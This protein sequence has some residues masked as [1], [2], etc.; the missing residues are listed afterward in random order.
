[1]ISYVIDQIIQLR[2][3]V[4]NKE[5]NTKLATTA[6]INNGIIKLSDHELSK[7]TQ[8]LIQNEEQEGDD[9]E[10]DSSTNTRLDSV[11]QSF[12][13]QFYRRKNWPSSWF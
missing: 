12:K 6:W 2:L 4:F 1:M 10:E 8:F 13:V 11:L 3:E 5:V 9:N 7:L